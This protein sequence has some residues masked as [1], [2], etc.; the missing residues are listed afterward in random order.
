MRVRLRVQQ[1]SVISAG[2]TSWLAALSALC[3]LAT[4]SSSHAAQDGIRFSCK[5]DQIPALKEGVSRYFSELAIAETLY[6]L[7]REDQG[8]SLTYTLRTPPED[9]N[10]LDLSKRPEMAVSLEPVLLPQ[11]GKPAQPVRTVSRKEI[12]LA[13][14]Q[15]GRLTVF[16]GAAC[17]VQAL[18]DHINLRQNIVAWSEEL[19][20]RWP[21]G[22]PAKWNTRYWHYGTPVRRQ[23]LPKALLDAFTNQHSYA[24]GC[25][26]ASKMVTLQGV[27]DFY[28]R[29]RGV[30]G[31]SEL[32]DGRVWADADPLV[33]IEPGDAW[34]F[35]EDFDPME[36]G[37]PGKLVK[38]HP[39]VSPKN[40]VPGD[41]AY[42]LNTDPGTHLKIGYEGSNALYLGRSL[43]DDYYDDHRHA[44]TYTEKLD[45]V[46]QWRNGVFSRARDAAK[47]KPLSKQ[48]F[49]QMGL[50]PEQGGM[51][52]GY[53]LVPYLF[54]YEPL[55]AIQPVVNAP[56]P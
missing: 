4:T 34:S 49:E 15:H 55:P 35:E 14:M 52:M 38:M 23:V 44:Y 10:T 50:P 1:K 33:N 18:K 28:Q 26:T 40:F 39:D 25:Y 53:R 11:L 13:L 12:A 17:D 56:Q 21:N 36:K 22:G 46:Y 51:V 45:E 32:V 2:R 20:W 37:R 24:I 43:F 5:A 8:A 19:H 41:W 6:Q 27:V 48:A 31:L 29:V 9:H 3:W 7:V 47:L 30:K 54:G 42:M 16:E